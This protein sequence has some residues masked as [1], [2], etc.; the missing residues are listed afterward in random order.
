MSSSH[1]PAK[2]GPLS[3]AKQALLE[4]RM[5]GRSGPEP[6]I[7]RS[8][9]L[10]P[11]VLSPGQQRLWFLHQLAPESAAYTMFDARRFS[12]PID[13][14]ALRRSLAGVV[15]RHEILR[16]C[17]ATH[18]GRPTAIVY[19]NAVVGFETIALDSGPGAEP[20]RVSAAEPDDGQ[21]E[22]DP[23]A[24][25]RPA[26][27]H[28][29][30]FVRRPFD[31]HAGP[32]LRAA[33][34]RLDP[35]DHVFVIAV[36]HIACDEWS[37]DVIWRELAVLYTAHAEGRPP[38]LEEPGLQY[39]DFAHWQ[40][41]R[42]TAR[43]VTGAANAAPGE[44]A[45]HLDYWRTTLAGTPAVFELPADRVPPAR[46]SFHG[47]LVA[48]RIAAGLAASLH[49][50]ARSSRTTSFVLHFTAFNVL[51]HR[52]TGETDFVVGVPATG[53]NRAELESVVGFFLNTLPLRM[54]LSG[55]PPFRELLRRVHASFLDAVT[56]QDTPF[57]A[58]VD[59]IAPHR[60]LNQN[61]L[62][63]VMFVDRGETAPV[64]FGDLI[65]ASRFHLST[66]T[67]KFDL[68]LFAGSSERGLET[69]IE[70]DADRFE[71]STATRMLGHYHTLLASACADP[72]C[73]ISR[74][75][76]A[77]RTERQ[78]IDEWSRGPALNGEPK[79]VHDQFRA[80]V[81]D[82][83]NSVATA[84]DHGS[85]SY[86]RLGAH[87]ASIARQLLACG[88][89][90]NERVA[91]CA[92]RSPEMIAGILG[93]LEAGAAYV[94][95]D[96]VY[97]RA[98]HDFAVADTGVRIVLATRTRAGQLP[99]TSRVLLLDADDA[100][101]PDAS[102]PSPSLHAVDP[103]D[104][105]DAANVSLTNTAYVLHTSGSTGAPRGVVVTHRNLACSTDA[106]SIAYP[107][108][109]AVF[110]LL[111]SF[112]FDSSVAGIFW[113]LATGGTL[114]LPPQRIEQDVHALA[115]FIAR[116]SVTHTLCLPSLWEAILEHA[117]PAALRTLRTVIV[118]GDACSARLIG[119]HYDVCPDVALW[120]E[121]GPTEA[122]VWSTVYAI[123]RGF[124]GTR[125]P[126]GRPVAGVRVHVLEPGGEP[127]PI[128]VPGELYIGG[129]GIAAGYA[130][131][132]DETARCFVPD[133]FGDSGARLYRTGD[134]ARW[135][136][137]GLLEF[138][139]RID[140][141]VKIRGYR[142]EPGEIESVLRQHPGVRESVVAVRAVSAAST[143]ANDIDGLVDAL[144]AMD[145]PDAKRI[146][147]VVE[148]LSSGQNPNGQP[149]VGESSQDSRVGERALPR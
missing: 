4:E 20:E 31:L 13:D 134:R 66:G 34:I 35:R 114:A 42:L 87:A 29:A 38:L 77:S 44:D 37:L 106:R 136:E 12:G 140:R 90:P 60:Q 147:E 123:P 19:P 117:P 148:Q 8:Q 61:P 26:H 39:R 24:R 144:S 112:A 110:M 133:P 141:Q 82:S 103:D 56:H 135:R 68:T 132:P 116:H 105:L 118:A 100:D 76:L 120:N 101:Q 128:G 111:S 143:A 15:Q 107:E 91:L 122:T 130:D 46:R 33:L 6:A 65:T 53:R 63:S 98:R 1:E 81:Q 58:I 52:Y 145:A 78:R 10:G 146:L 119:R 45:T 80:R 85:L 18:D 50:L 139:G 89:D 84:T 95:L 70:Y 22:S 99:A 47:G 64:S 36:H 129:P 2:H 102:G 48:E 59:T 11:P 7:R 86:A 55:D 71:S 92:D 9:G 40:V 41:E 113:T 125:V 121:Y 27:E 32:V 109:P 97:P 54:D 30:A 142:I 43:G 57:E 149:D 131:R 5:R 21:A 93:I 17:Y 94:P 67:A 96:P 124:E 108:P 73:R 79:P 3:A 49:A 72:D 126:I 25:L 51:L 115:A 62:F 23:L 69:M 138:L 104:H 127:A 16:T 14:G 74:L 28:A 88:V 75:P 137:D 83:A